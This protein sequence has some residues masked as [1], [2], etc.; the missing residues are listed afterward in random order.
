MCITPATLG[1]TSRWLT[2][3]PRHYKILDRFVLSFT[4]RMANYKVIIL[5]NLSVQNDFLVQFNALIIHPINDAVKPF[6]DAKHA[7]SH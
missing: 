5:K 2:N 7:A 6:V 1:S 4:A 3:A